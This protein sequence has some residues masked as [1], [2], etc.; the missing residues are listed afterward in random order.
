MQA[1]M[2]FMKPIRVSFCTKYWY[3]YCTNWYDCFGFIGV[4]ICVKTHVHLR[5]S[6][7]LTI[8][9]MAHKISSSSKISDVIHVTCYM[10]QSNISLHNEW[11]MWLVW[12]SSR[13]DYWCCHGWWDRLRYTLVQQ[14]LPWPACIACRTRRS[15]QDMCAAC[16]PWSLQIAPLP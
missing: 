9:A 2:G 15:T 10:L 14:P 1:L 6:M 3:W 5:T 16:R 8:V 11:M 12:L 4:W 7:S 13:L